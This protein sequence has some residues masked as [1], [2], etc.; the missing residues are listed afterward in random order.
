MDGFV[1]LS[2]AVN[3]TILAIDSADHV[4]GKTG[5]AAGF[6][7]YATK[8]AGSPA[9]ITP[10]VTELDATNVKGLYKLALTSSHTDTLGELTLHIT[11]SGM[12][13]LD[14]KWQVATY[15]PGEAATLQADQAVNTTKWAGTTVSVPTVAGVP[16]V[17]V[18]TWNDLTT[19]ALPL[20][21]TTAG[22]TLVVD[23]AGL[24]DANVVKLGPSGSGTA[25]TAKDVG[26]AVPAAVAGAA[27]GLFIAGTN[28]PVTI[29]GSGDAL[30]ITSTG[31]NGS[32]VNITSN[33]SGH[34][35][36][37]VGG[38]TGFG[39]N[40]RGGATSGEG[41]RA[42]APTSG[43]GLLIAGGNASPGLQVNGGATGAGVSVFGGATSGVGM[44][45]NTTSGDSLQLNPTAGHGLMALADGTSKHGI[46]ATGG[47]AG[48]SDGMSVVAG[49]GGVS[50]RA[51]AVTAAI[52]GNVTGNL[53]GSVGSV[54]GA[55][56][57]V[58]GAVGSVTGAVGSVTGAVGSVTG[59]V[60]GNVTGSVGS[61][62]TG[63]IAAAS[64][65]ASA[66]DASAIAAN[67]IGASELADGAIDAATFAASAIDATAIASNAITAA[68]I[69][70]DALTDAKFDSTG[71][72]RSHFT[73]V[74]KGLTAAGGS[75]TTIVLNALTGIDGG[76]PSATNDF[77]NGRV[78]VFTS[79]ALAGQATSISA[80]A[81]ATQTLTVVAL[82]GAPAAAVTLVIV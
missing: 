62:A 8:A 23:A 55:V 77:Y 15:L 43:V 65:A 54:T 37:T 35:I 67:A 76:V 79:G 70:S 74:L 75:T 16:N 12:D 78:V 27:G 4:T 68:K 81:G 10:T 11:G 6:T 18:K 47:T 14:L 40:A 50:L 32:G 63:G 22:R 71:K 36:L 60:G 3:I 41:I 38:T 26:A 20:V 58:T 49:S 61:I 7:I 66:I 5:L 39:I 2:T 34:G 53:S 73:A 45:I 21:P 31:A 56:G 13:P 24:A 69:A 52:T 82:T 80:Y 48:T 25:Q 64:F 17:N 72:L 59:N 42:V 51:P 46:F 44:K 30:T 1:K 29:T 28:A 57:S 9:T 19:V 33:G